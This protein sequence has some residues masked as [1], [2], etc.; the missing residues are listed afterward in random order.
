MPPPDLLIKRKAV[1]DIAPEKEQQRLAAT[2]SYNKP[3]YAIMH[4]IAKDK[5]DEIR[6]EPPAEDP[7]IRR[8]NSQLRTL[9]NPVP[10]KPVVPDYV[11]ES[12]QKSLQKIEE[13]PKGVERA[14]TTEEAA[15]AIEEAERL[16]YQIYENYIG[17][18]NVEENTDNKTVN[19]LEQVGKTLGEIGAKL[20]DGVS[21]VANAIATF[22]RGIWYGIVGP[23]PEEDLSDE[24]AALKGTGTVLMTAG[25]GGAAAA[26]ATGVGVPAAAALGGLSLLGWALVDNF[27]GRLEFAQA[28]RERERK[29]KEKAQQLEDAWR[30]KREEDLRA[31]E[32]QM[33]LWAQKKREEREE[34]QKMIEEIERERRK[35]REEEIEFW[36]KVN[37]ERAKAE[38]QRRREEEEERRFY[39]ITTS[40][41]SRAE[42]L[43]SVLQAASNAYFAKNYETALSLLDEAEGKVKELKSTI[44]ANRELLQKFDYYAAFMDQARAIENAIAANRKAWS[45][46]SPNR[47]LT[48]A[49]TN[50]ANSTYQFNRH[51]AKRVRTTGSF[52]VFDADDVNFLYKL[53]RTQ[54]KNYA[55]GRLLS[56]ATLFWLNRIPVIWYPR[57]KLAP[58]TILKFRLWLKRQK[59]TPLAAIPN[60]AWNLAAGYS[61]SRYML[62]LMIRALKDAKVSLD[63]VA[64]LKLR[65]LEAILRARQYIYVAANRGY[66]HPYELELYNRLKELLMLTDYQAE[67]LLRIDIPQAGRE[68][69][70]GFE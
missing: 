61:Y 35:R 21:T 5:A 12:V 65:E 34:Y 45:G 43:K 47:E 39:A 60:S 68:V 10:S 3:D 26:A 59:K 25:A 58:Q 9:L 46:K 29:E 15:K 23:P 69:K 7:E 28:E 67:K 37:E 2:F 38:E 57:S 44:E 13:L 55:V 63:E 31:F 4:T 52:N 17:S 16:A 51:A 11:T 50:Y 14:M 6:S 53:L 18:K 48:N 20:V 49:V 40:L 70:I 66:W 30:R 42:G 22:G 19:I 27:A 24:I 64:N 32:R 62:M 8:F 36:R 56:D 41:K 33:E 54:R 1:P